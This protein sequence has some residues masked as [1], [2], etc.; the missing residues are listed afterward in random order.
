MNRNVRL[1]IRLAGLGVAMV[2]LLANLPAGWTIGLV[3]VGLATFLLAGG[4]G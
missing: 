3:G 4:G 2:G 1:L